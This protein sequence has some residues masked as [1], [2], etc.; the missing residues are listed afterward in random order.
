MTRRKTGVDNVFGMLNRIFKEAQHLNRIPVIGEFNISQTH[1]MGDNRTD[2]R[3]EDYLDLSDSVT[4]Q[5]DQGCHKPTASHLDWMKEQELDLASYAPDKVYNLAA[6]EIVT[7]E[8]NQHYD[9]LIRRD[10]TFKYAIACKKYKYDR[11][12]IDF[13][14]SEKVN[15]LTDK[16]LDA[17]GISRHDA[18]A[19]QHYFL[20]RVNSS[21][22]DQQYD[23]IPLRKVYYACLHVRAAFEDRDY[24]QPIFPFVAAKEQIESVVKHA[25]RK[26]SRLYIMSDIHQPDFFDFLK[27]DYRVYRYYDFPKLRGLVS[28]EGGKKID[29]VMLY[30][31]EKNI[32]KY[33]TVKILAPHKAPM[34]YNLNTLYDLTF[35][36]KPPSTRSIYKKPVKKRLP[37]RLFWRQIKKF[38]VTK[39]KKLNPK[40]IVISSLN[41]NLLPNKYLLFS[42]SGRKTGVDNVFGM[43]NLIFREAQYLNRIPVIG[44]FTISSTHNLGDSRINLRFEDY[45]D[46]SNSILVQF[47]QGGHKSSTL[48]QGW[49]KEEEFDLASYAPDKVYS[50]AADE[51]VS[52]ELNQRYDVLVRRDPAFDYVSTCEK[53]QHDYYIDFPYSE[54]VNRTVDETLNVLGVSRKVAMASQ[55]YFLNRTNHEISGLQ[56]EDISLDKVYYACMHVRASIRDRDYGQPIFPF[57]ASKK[58]IQSVLKHSISK[59]S[60]LY[61]MSDIHRTEFSDF[62][63]SDYQVYRYYDFPNLRK[64]VSGEDGSQI[65]NVMLYLVEKN[66]MKYAT[67]KILP[68]HKGPMSY[69]LNTVYDLSLF[70][71]PPSTREKQDSEKVIRIVDEMLNALGISREDAMTAQRYFLDRVNSSGWDQQH[72]SIP[73]NKVYYACMHLPALTEGRDNKRRIFPFAVSKEQIKSVLEHSI[74]KGSRLYVMSDIHQRDFFDFL[75]SD[76]KVYRYYNFPNLRKLVSGKGGKKIDNAMLYLVEDNIMKYA[77]VKILP[78]YKGPM[79]Y[80]LNTTYDLSILKELPTT[81]ERPDP[82][83]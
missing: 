50:L 14:Y 64:L 82:Q 63:R 13:L 56:H 81:T 78:P 73:L 76:Y 3:F 10:P 35:L 66:I 30:L 67:V 11:Y 31:V 25:I 42:M 8:M 34:I 46:L 71:E 36:K 6:D 44:T 37:T 21:G 43:L 17:F 2:L 60:R 54:K 12:L 20:N 69:H 70:K 1:N 41:K 65:D 22:W 29:N 32:M 58:Q 26:R 4:V 24:E 27:S 19:A 53:Y 7:E 28:G 23:S 61:I 72:D 83:S 39:R 9:V 57:S 38:W 48:N 52:E 5:L 49:I 59:G 33:A 18:M 74:S 16:V 79:I 62:L 68:P 75:K 45:L 51:I 47:E 77:T 55:H 40:L 15:S 80:H